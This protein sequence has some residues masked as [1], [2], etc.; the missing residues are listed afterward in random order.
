V[1]PHG[2]GGQVLW[3]CGRGRSELGSARAR[4]R[5]S[6][7]ISTLHGLVLWGPAVTAAE[8]IC[9]RPSGNRRTLT[10]NRTRRPFPRTRNELPGTPC[11]S[12]KTNIDN[13]ILKNINIYNI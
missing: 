3:L 13:Y 2:P 11:A 5:A 9:A 1:P 7:A 10:V 6:G 12:K 8:H 4:V